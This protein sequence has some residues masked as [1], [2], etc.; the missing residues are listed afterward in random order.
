MSRALICCPG[1]S[2]PD[3]Y[4]LTR[5]ATMAGVDE[6]RTVIAVN[7]AIALVDADW[8]AAG[9]IPMIEILRGKR[10]RP[11]RGI[12]AL[13]ST[14]TECC[15]ADHWTGLDWLTWEDLALHEAHNAALAAAGRR[16][17]SWSIQSALLLAHHL[18]HS[19]ARV[20]GA[21]MIGEA[22]CTGFVGEDRSND[23]WQRERLDLKT[24]IAVLAENGC[25][26]EG[27]AGH[28]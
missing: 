2:L 23:R 17:I 3:A 28:G 9:D 11:R 14:V 25:T 7:N 1:K 24:T 12:L 10:L 15:R 22:D 13:S 27:I 8:L 5:M 6:Y 19:V 16:P 26:V 18:G 4:R 21:D 20:I